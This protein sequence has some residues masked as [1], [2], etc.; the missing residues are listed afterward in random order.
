MNKALMSLLA[1]IL[2]IQLSGYSAAVMAAGYTQTRYPIV[3][4][5]GM[6]GFDSIA[7][8]NYWY[9][10]PRALQRDGAQVFVTQV[11]ALNS[12]EQRGEQLLAQVEDI[13][14]ITGAEKV[15]L[16]GH[17]HGGQSVRY[18]AAVMPQRVASV[19]TV[20]SP[21]KGSAAADLGLMALAL[22]VVGDALQ[23][24]VTS[25]LEGLG[26][27]IG[28]AAG[29]PLPQNA[30]DSLNSLSSAGT[31]D[32]NLRFPQGVPVTSCGEGAYES[33]GVKQ[34]SWSGVNTGVTH[35]FD[36]SSY[37]MVLTKLAFNEQNDGLVG[38]C[39]SHFG[40][41]LR[42]DYPMDHLDEVNQLFGLAYVFSTNPK[43]V[44]RQHANRLRNLGL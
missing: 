42:D 5:H 12:S 21:V 23:P 22:P 7:G 16:I 19:T 35:F 30:L 14:A 15:N 36:P 43:T 17:S 3:L 24:V 39:S 32:F 29:E 10:I 1:L 2:A 41:V 20:G 33:N 28:F 8:I 26:W 40:Q 27:L 34:F 9:G 18:V 25:V 38:R 4:A 13:L 31:T 11:S 44:Y 37:A 6:F